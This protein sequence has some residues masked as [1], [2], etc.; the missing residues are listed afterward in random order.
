MLPG[1]LK[2]G[3]AELLGAEPAAAAGVQHGHGVLRKGR[4]VARMSAES[5]IRSPPSAGQVA[6]GRRRLV[7]RVGGR[8][9]M[10]A[11]GAGAQGGGLQRGGAET[12]IRAG[13]AV[14]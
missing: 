8:A 6:V 2:H 4:E 7:G 1:L 3:H 10:V 9:G 12:G 14:T 11:Q 13:S 5:V